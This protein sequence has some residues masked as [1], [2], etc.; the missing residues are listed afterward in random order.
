MPGYNLIVIGTSAGGVDT[1]EV[2]IAGL[3]HALPAAIGIVLDCSPTGPGRPIAIL[4]QVG[5][6]PVTQVAKRKSSGLAAS[7]WRFPIL[8][9]WP[10]RATFGSRGG[11]R[12]NPHERAVVSLSNLQPFILRRPLTGGHSH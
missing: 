10:S 4:T 3:P 8:T 9:Y 11:H 12:G 5:S 6:L 1:F 7:L 2:W